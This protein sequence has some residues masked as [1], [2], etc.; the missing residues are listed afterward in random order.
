MFRKTVLTAAA[1]AMAAALV[2]TVPAIA[3]DIS[4]AKALVK[5]FAGR[6]TVWDGPTAGPKALS[7]KTVVVVAAD[8]KNGGVLGVANGVEEAAAAIGWGGVKGMCPRP[9]SVFFALADPRD[10]PASNFL[11]ILAGV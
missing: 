11:E 4:E 2:P 1:V 3:D 8:M 5:K 6:K 9:V 10:A 7:G